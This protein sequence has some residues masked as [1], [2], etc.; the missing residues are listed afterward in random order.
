MIYET[1]NSILQVR[2]LDERK[3]SST[4]YRAWFPS[5]H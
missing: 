4:G 2:R 3:V 5:F 1:H